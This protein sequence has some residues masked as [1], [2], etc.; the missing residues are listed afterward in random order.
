MSLTPRQQAIATLVLRG[1][2]NAAIA[3]ALQ[4]RYPGLT[5]R[6]VRSE[7]FTISRMYPGSLPARQRIVMYYPHK[8][9]P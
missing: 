7:C 4:K 2:G 9:A 6:T 3:D 1:H 8:E 5:P